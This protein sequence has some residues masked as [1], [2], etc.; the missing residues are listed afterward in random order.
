VT[1]ETG[2]VRQVMEDVIQRIAELP[3]RDSPDDW[4]EAMLVTAD[5]LRTIL[6]DEFGGLTNQVS[7]L[8]AKLEKSCDNTD[9]AIEGWK[10]A[11]ASQ[12]APSG[13]Q[14]RIAAMEPWITNRHGATMC[15]FCKVGML[16]HHADDCLWQNAVD[17]LPPAPEKAALSI[18]QGSVCLLPKGSLGLPP[19]PEVKDER[20]SCYGCDHG[21]VAIVRQDITRPICGECGS[22]SV[23]TD[24]GYDF[25]A[26]HPV[27]G[28]K[29]S[30]IDPETGS[31]EGMTPLCEYDTKRLLRADAK[32][33]I[34]P[35][36]PQREKDARQLIDT[37]L[38]EYAD[39]AAPTAFDT[40]ENCGPVAMCSFHS[41]LSMLRMWQQAKD[42]IPPGP[43]GA[44]A[45]SC[46]V[47]G[48]RQAECECPAVVRSIFNARTEKVMV[49]RT[50]RL[51]HC[52]RC[53]Y[54]TNVSAETH[55]P[56]MCDR[57]NCGGTTYAKAD[58]SSVKEERDGQ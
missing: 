29:L 56:M 27:P 20:G 38:V 45:E 58:A 48:R 10:R 43:E 41:V 12:P 17:A 51:Y 22:A 44:T 23:V 33:V 11:L 8:T 19:A 42:A 14:Q 55:R 18:A 21:D 50:T 39:E 30:A 6:I 40:C 5:E 32:D 24:R 26:R 15:V 9:R 25:K 52:A 4:P 37:L 57:T 53:G 47:C 16:Q 34:P 28:A 3:D 1:H 7:L 2:D 13:W 35:Q 54:E 49:E 31:D 36:L 46:G